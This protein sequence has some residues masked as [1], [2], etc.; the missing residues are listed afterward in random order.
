MEIE[1]CI[2][3]RLVANG[4]RFD[5]AVDFA[6]AT[7]RLM[8]FGPSGSGKSLT[9]SALAGLMRPDSGFIRVDG[10]AFFDRAAGVNLPARQRGIGLVFQDYALFPHLRVEENVAFGLYRGW[11][12][13]LNR[14]SRR[15]VDAI[16]AR[17]VVADLARGFPHELSGGQRQRVA[18]ARALV[19][20]PQLLLL[21][22]PFSALDCTLRDRLRRELQRIVGEFD[23][24]TVLISHDPADLKL[25]GETVVCFDGGIASTARPPVRSCAPFGLRTAE[26]V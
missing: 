20:E 9:L 4:R 3:K 22:E 19:G 13:R 17:L 25:F 24:P 16:M 14:E 5:L 18:L 8:L 7:R 12:F 23:V 10:R 15:R 1:V 21:D 11:P 6:S 2:R 26:C